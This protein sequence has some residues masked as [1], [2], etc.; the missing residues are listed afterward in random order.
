MCVAID[1][2]SRVLTD[3][4]YNGYPGKRLFPEAIL[5]VLRCG[6]NIEHVIKT[7]FLKKKHGY[8]AWFKQGYKINRD[9]KLPK[10]LTTALHVGSH[11]TL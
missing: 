5:T 11:M 9:T 10:A 1:S 8:E 2:L 3:T 7:T 4:L 6:Q